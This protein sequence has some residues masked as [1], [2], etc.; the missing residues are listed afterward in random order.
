M[1]THRLYVSVAPGSDQA[2][3]KSLLEWVKRSQKQMQMNGVKVHV[4][5][6]VTGADIARLQANG[7]KGLPALVWAVK[8]GPPMAAIGFREV[9]ARL[10]AAARPPPQ[11]AATAEDEL[12]SWYRTTLKEGDEEEKEDTLSAAVAAA[13]GKRTAGPPKKDAAPRP[14]NIKEDGDDEILKTISKLSSGPPGDDSDG[15]D[16]LMEQSYY[17]N[18]EKSLPEDKDEDDY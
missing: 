5:A 4:D 16:D 14:A 6:V 3:T 7:I 12:R 15:R 8:G 17:K 9:R 10:D 1:S 11:T 2:A 18:R 13:A